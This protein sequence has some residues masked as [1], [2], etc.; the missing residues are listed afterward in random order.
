MLTIAVIGCGAIGTALLETIQNDSNLCV[1]AIVVPQAWMEQAQATVTRLAP[2]AQV[3]E[4]VPEEGIDLVV[5]VAGHSA[6]EGHVLPALRRGI[7]AIVASVG[8]LSSSDLAEQLEAAAVAGGTRVEL[9]AGAIGAVDA[10]AAAR[11]GGL[12]AVVYT[13]RK[14]AHAWQ[15]TPAEEAF[16]LEHLEAP[17]VIFEGS[18][19]EAARLYPKNANVA[20]TI[21]LAGLGLDQTRVRLLADPGA[22]RNTHTVEASGAFGELSLTMSNKPLASNPKTSALTV[23]SAVRALRNSADALAI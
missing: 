6:I 1:G 16:D 13:G 9:I 5:E 19:R 17:T 22:Q 2:K 15:G 18:A 8:A 21:S 11:I 14:P 12:D 20:A 7:P 10:I 3:G 23:F 4:Y